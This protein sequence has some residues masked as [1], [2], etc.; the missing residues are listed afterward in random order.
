M[1]EGRS[2]FLW[3]AAAAILIAAP[4]SD[5]GTNYTWVP[6]AGGT[7]NWN[8]PNNWHPSFGVPSQPTDGANFSINLT[9][10]L[11]VNLPVSEIVG[12]LTLGATG[13]PFTTDI[14]DG[15]AGGGTLILDNGSVS[16]EIDIT[17]AGKAG[18]L[19]V[20]SAPIQANGVITILQGGATGLLLNGGVTFAGAS[21]GG[22][23]ITNGLTGT[24]ALSIGNITTAATATPSSDITIGVALN[25]PTGNNVEGVQTILDGTISDG[26]PKAG[27]N[28]HTEL[29]LGGAQGPLPPSNAIYV[30]NGNNTYSGGTTLSPSIVV[31][32][33]DKAFGTGIVQDQAKTIDTN[34]GC[35]FASTDDA[36]TI[37]NT[38]YM[39]G[40]QIISGS[41][42]LTWSGVFNHG[43]GV[44]YNV[45]PASKSFTFANTVAMLATF[46]IDGPSQTVVNG[47]LI[48]TTTNP[49]GG[50]AIVKDGD[51]LLRL[52]GVNS[53]TGSTA[54]NGGLVE[55]SGPGAIGQ[56]T[57]A[58]ANP[59]GAIGVDSGSTSAAF[60]NLLIAAGQPNTGALALAP[61]DAAINL[62]FNSGNMSNANVA[63]MSIGAVS[64]G[65]TYTGTITPGGSGYRLGGGGTLTLPNSQLTGANNLTITNG[66]A[67]VLSG[68]NNFT[69]KTTIQ[70]N[71]IVSN[72]QTASNELTQ[73][74][75]NG[76]TIGVAPGVYEPEKL[77]VMH[78]ADGA[79]SI[80][81]PGDTSAASL[82]I[83]GGTLQYAGNAA[84]ST[85]RL[86]SIG[87]LGATIDSSGPGAV[88]FSNTGEILC[89]D[90]G[91]I[92]G[93]VGTSGNGISGVADVSQL[94]V[95]M[96][97]N[98]PNFPAGTKIVGIEA[99]F[100][101]NKLVGYGLTLD[102]V[103][104][105]TAT[106]TTITFTTQNR[107]LTLT[108]TNT[109]NNTIAGALADSPTGQLSVN[110]TGTGTWVLTGSNTYTGAT[111]VQAGMLVFG[112][113][114]TSG[115]AVNVSDGASQNRWHRHVVSDAV[116]ESQHRRHAR[117][118][119]QRV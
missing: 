112:S 103:A 22:G 108:G 109:G 7:Y 92:T 76:N 10:D 35:D 64:G 16:N 113:T 27:F 26:L 49:S 63:S 8:N 85:I 44:F 2:C 52:T 104:T 61:V 84:Q 119:D 34:M 37:A 75:I 91:A 82:V 111:N 86:F 33:S 81:N 73:I 23:S 15:N 117:S 50:G 105:G 13:A 28:V 9:G 114:Y 71:Y 5:A 87:P 97:I 21:N 102:H 43:A 55:F 25:Y 99:S 118:H 74:T 66:G 116:A 58:I 32:G 107:T 70:G 18:A 94:A 47:N 88:A 78:L 59:G 1:K 93:N 98:N 46:V 19:N 48:F 68:I 6:T 90:A 110:K 106:G 56:S 45:L 40:T 67:V 41:H 29:F 95:G 69:G 77:T 4:G 51:G 30:L 101:K 54:A 38:M 115:S 14:G 39:G 72:E 57:S 79:S 53:Y 62:D 11:R 96:S 36:R 42:S 89:N 83:N 24:N 60:L 31:L 17:S 80:G 65:A 12:S 100:L 3:S 20:I